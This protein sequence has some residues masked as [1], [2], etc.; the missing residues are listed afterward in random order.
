MWGPSDRMPATMIEER[1]MNI[2]GSAGTAMYRF[3]GDLRKVDFL[4]YDVTNLAYAIRHS[5]RAAV[6]GVGGGRDLLSAYLFGF[7]DV[8][9]VE[10]N[11]IFVRLLRYDFH[12]FSSLVDLPG[13]QLHVDEA[14]SWFARS[15]DHFDL[16]QMSMIDT[17]ASTGAGAFSLSENGLYT[18]E[19]W[20]T[21]LD[22]LSDHGVLTV[23]R[24]YTPQRLDETGRLL[25]L[26]AEAL[27]R[28]GSQKP[29]AH[30]F[31]AA[32]HKLATLVL[33]RQPL[34]YEDV[35]TLEHTAANLGF[36]VLVAPGARATS[37]T[38]DEI[39]SA[40]GPDAFERLSSAHHIDLSPA[41]DARPFFFQQLRMTDPASWRRGMHGAPGVVR[42][43]LIATLTLLLV[44][45]LSCGLVLVTVVV[46]TIPSIRQTPAWLAWSGTLYFMLIGLGFMFVE[47]GL[48][49]R[50]SV[51]LGHPVYGLAIG[52][53]G[54]IVSTGLGSL[55]SA[56]VPLSTNARFASW[57][58]I[59]ALYLVLLPLWLSRLVVLFA[60]ATLTIR[61]LV[62]LLAI[63]PSGVLMGF[64]FP[65]GMQRVNAVDAG[66][67]PW[68][69]A[70][71]GAAGVFAAALAVAI[72]IAFSI[73][74]TFWLGA[75]CYALLAP[76]AW[77]LVQAAAPQGSTT[78]A[79]DAIS[80]AR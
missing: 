26:A 70:V 71:N 31:L 48:I 17:W 72:S 43:N 51:Y 57:A 8:T 34:S 80:T 16:I 79:G 35:N 28:S 58:G 3:D 13:V 30:I 44:T 33:S 74:V 21:F 11:P 36:S 62:C 41:T 61:A 40:S 75:A 23:S 24:W 6:I 22:H 50:I 65:T 5:G 29:A 2:D 55:L 42:G 47:I 27:R 63:V 46:P 4:R 20:Q 7:R 49:Q 15:R 45:A 73:N 76:A 14:R 38:L 1:S 68:F 18:V 64:G 10:L 9:G 39:E 78:R 19:G 54:I 69:W 37:A 56:R 12:D 66:P 52:L 67:T 60:S 32:T 77:G 59:L 53:F 25:S